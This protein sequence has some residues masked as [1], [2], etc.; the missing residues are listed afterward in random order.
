L[1]RSYMEDE[2][3]HG[4]PPDDVD[5]R[6]LACVSYESFFSIRLIAQTLGLA[7]ATVYDTLPYPGTCN[8]DT[9]DGSPMC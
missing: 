7:P 9:P 8:L 5:A 4:L 1:G 2:A 6:I 3:K